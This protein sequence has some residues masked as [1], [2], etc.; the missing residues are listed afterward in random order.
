ME[1]AIVQKTFS[2]ELSILGEKLAKA[3]GPETWALM[4]PQLPELASAHGFEIDTMLI[5]V[6]VLMAVLFIGWGGFFLFTLFRF[7][8]RLNPQADYRGVRSHVSTYLE[9][10][11]AVIEALLLV[12]LS[13]PFWV[14]QVNAFPNRTDTFEVRVVAEQFA[15]SF[16]YP[17]EDGLFGKTAPEFVDLASN[18]VGIDWEDPSAKDDFYTDELHLPIGKPAILHITSKDVVHSFALPHFRVKQDAIPGMSIPTWFTPTR[19]GNFEIACA[20]LCGNS[21]Y[22]MRGEAFIHHDEEWNDWLLANA[23]S[24]DAGDWVEGGDGYDPFWN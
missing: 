1:D 3:F 7:N 13:I 15:W 10:I 19:S 16:H 24:A 12:G 4:K 17:G 2:Q 6:H 21:H 8:R 11:V 22:K 18:P 20:Q 5:A 14:K 23:P 9:V